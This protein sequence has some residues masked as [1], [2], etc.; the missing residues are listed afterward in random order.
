MR[1][2]NHQGVLVQGTPLYRI[3]RGYCISPRIKIYLHA[4]VSNEAAA[5]NL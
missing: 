5:Y 3:Y 2:V 4:Q 1:E